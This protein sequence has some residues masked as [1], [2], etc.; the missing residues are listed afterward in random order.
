MQVKWT[1][2]LDGR[3]PGPYFRKMT[4]RR[5][6][7]APDPVLRQIS[8]PVQKVDVRTRALMDDMLET[9]YSAKGIGLAAIQIGI[10]LRVIVMD[11]AGDEEKPAPRYFVNPQIS[12]LSEE[13][14]VYQE[15]CLSLPG[16][17]DNVVR[18]L[19]CRVQ[20]LD[21]NGAECICSADGLFA[22]CIQHEM[23][24][25]EGIIF[26]D[27]LSRIKRERIMKKLKKEQ[28]FATM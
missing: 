9:M 22:T 6:I 27:R 10:P 21:Y 2:H 19:R 26:P 13:T 28:R 17:Y 1:V 23:D 4:V 18:P 25:L 11:L 14:G 15:G 16:Y 7:T 20:Y 12:A 8:E 5:I 24:H 3:R